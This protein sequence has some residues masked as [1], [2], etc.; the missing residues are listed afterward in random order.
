MRHVRGE[1]PR[2]Q[3]RLLDKG[4]L[5]AVERHVLAQ[6]LAAGDFPFDSVESYRAFPAKSLEPGEILGWQLRDH[7]LR[8]ELLRFG[9]CS[10]FAVGFLRVKRLR[11][12]TGWAFG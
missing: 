9:L 2:V 3:S 12:I 5:R 1:H 6:L 11:P 7:R 8:R 10:L 4:S